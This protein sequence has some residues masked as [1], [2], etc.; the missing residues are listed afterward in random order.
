MISV[1]DIIEELLVVDELM[2]KAVVV[3]K[4]IVEL[5]VD[6]LLVEEVDE[7]LVKDVVVVK[8]LTSKLI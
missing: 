3:D 1:V 7:L 5:L 4:A 8:S 6:G 2:L